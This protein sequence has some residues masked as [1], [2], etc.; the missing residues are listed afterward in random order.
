MASRFYCLNPSCGADNAFVE[1]NTTGDIVCSACGRVAEARIIDNQGEWRNFAD[2][3]K[4]RARAQE[5]DEFLEDLGTSVQASWNPNDGSKGELARMVKRNTMDLATRNLAAAA[6]RISELCSRMGFPDS[7]KDKAKTLYKQFDESKTK[8]VRGGKNDALYCA[9]LYLALKE[10]DV[11][12]TFKEL[13]TSSA[14]SEAEIRK[15]YKIVTRVL[16]SNFKKPQPVNPADLV[17]RYCSRINLPPAVVHLAAEIARKA[18]SKLEG[19][20]PSSIA[21]ASIYMAAKQ[22]EREALAKDI[23]KAASIAPSTIQAIYRE[24]LQWADELLPQDAMHLSSPT[25]PRS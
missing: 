20:S 22:S 15:F 9:I 18:F 8:I 2:S 17:N 14:V 6:S 13:A 19:K 16:P 4:D 11:P 1:D 12:R 7:I 24:M 25:T 3:D 21:S 10:E 5:T 23:A